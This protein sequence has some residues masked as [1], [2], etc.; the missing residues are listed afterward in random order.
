MTIQ[1]INHYTLA[2]PGGHCSHVV[3]AA[4]LIALVEQSP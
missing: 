2:A 1:R 3:V 4:G